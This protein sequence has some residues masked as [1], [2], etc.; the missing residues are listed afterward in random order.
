M[1]PIVLRS[2]IIDP[3]LTRMGAPFDR[4]EAKKLLGAIALQESSLLHR[5]Q[6]P[7]GPAVGWWQFERG[8]GI[9]GVVHHKTSRMY[10]RDWCLDL[11]IAF[12][13]DAIYEAIE[14]NDQLACVCARLLLYT[15]PAPLPTDQAGGWGYYQRN[16]RPGK[17]RPD[18]WPHNWQQAL[19]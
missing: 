9:A 11:S 15:D 19:P 1:T 16:W 4:P 12:T 6:Y 18:E 5:V 8:G 10:L 13:V 3:V 7:I 2:L 17:P 14:F